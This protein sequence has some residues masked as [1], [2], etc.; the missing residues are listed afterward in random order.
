MSY[1]L[2][3]V[4]TMNIQ[5]IVEFLQLIFTKDILSSEFLELN[6]VYLS[7]KEEQLLS[8][9]IS[10]FLSRNSRRLK[11]KEKRSQKF[12]RVMKGKVY[13]LCFP[14]KLSKTFS[15]KSHLERNEITTALTDYNYNVT[16][17]AINLED[18]ESI[19]TKT[20][21][22][23]KLMTIRIK[24]N[25]MFCTLTSTK[26][27]RVI[28]ATSTKYRIK[29]SK[30]AL[31]YNYK[32]I[33]KAFIDETKKFFGRKMRISLTA[34]KRIRRELLRILKKKLTLKKKSAKDT[35]GKSIPVIPRILLFHFK[36]KKCFNG[37]RARKKKRNK[38]RGLRIYK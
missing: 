2:L 33:L 6:Y 37:C 31:R 17:E 12:I 25:N 16:S 7:Q 11:R 36:A 23:D 20:V 4:A 28:S 30:K 19:D 8:M 21:M 27:K 26:K 18:K 38:Q 32:L 13:S 24:P 22:F 35:L 34:P 14:S 29:M 3:I 15:S 1:C 10:K 5:K 9:K